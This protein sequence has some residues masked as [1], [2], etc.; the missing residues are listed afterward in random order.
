MQRNPERV[1][2][3]SP[4]LSTQ[5]GTRMSVPLALKLV[6]VSWLARLNVALERGSPANV[7]PPSGIEL[8]SADDQR[9]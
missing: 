5:P 7:R 3:S 9:S 4:T 1:L 8:S 6:R 2:L